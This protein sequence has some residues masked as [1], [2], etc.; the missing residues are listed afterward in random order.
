[1]AVKTLAEL[2]T[3]LDEGLAWRRAELRALASELESRESKSPDAPLTRALSRAGVALLYAHWE[4]YAKDACEAYLDYVAVRRLRFDELGDGFLLTALK[5]LLR[6]LEAGDEVAS[7]T[8]MDL[9]R[10]P[11]LARARVPRKAVINTRSNLRHDVLV[12]MCAA[13]GLPSEDFSTRK[14]FIDRSLCDARNEIAHGRLY[15]PEAATFSQS[16][17][18]VLGMLARLR[19]SVIQHARNSLYKRDQAGA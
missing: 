4:G 15:F 3:F 6:R 13:V 1:M 7:V 9:V 12:E 18:D 8:A 2:E 11:E 10:R 17:E 14:Q 5:S 16:C 19:S